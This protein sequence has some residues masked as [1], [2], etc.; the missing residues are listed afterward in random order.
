[1]QKALERYDYIQSKI[2]LYSSNIE[3]IDFQFLILTQ[4]YIK[5]TNPISLTF[6]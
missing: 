2:Y 6:Q 5:R 1:M 3:D 4:N